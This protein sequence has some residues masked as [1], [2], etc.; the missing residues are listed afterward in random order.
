MISIIIPVF[1]SHKFLAK[2][3]DSVL[4][5][6]YSNIEI[7]CVNN[8]ST[9]DSLDILKAYK[10]KDNRVKI[11][12]QKY[13]NGCS[14]ARNCALKR[15]RGKYIFFLDDD[16]FL[17][18]EYVLEHLY[19]A[20]NESDLDFVGSKVKVFTKSKE[21]ALLARKKSLE[22]YFSHYS[23]MPDCQVSPENLR[24]IMLKLPAVVWGRLYSANYLKTHKLEFISYKCSTEDEGFKVKLLSTFPKFSIIDC[25]GVCYR[26]RKGTVSERLSRDET[27]KKKVPHVARALA[28]AML[29]VKQ[30]CSESDYK[31][32]VAVVEEKYNKY[33]VDELFD[34]Y[35]NKYFDYLKSKKPFYC[36]Q[37]KTH[38]IYGILGI[39]FK[40]RIK[41]KVD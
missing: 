41:D 31:L 11:I 13:N 32:I 30:C 29:Y 4:S 25:I 40:F 1:N 23:P 5:Q 39:K 3:L 10:R 37:T 22:K 12:N 19:N 21:E 27:L 38:K 24:E 16:D 28:D 18:D 33:V 17:Y 34:V 35:K 9:D 36:I 15:V 7:I 14:V 26:I 20:I 2:C 8:A 6:T